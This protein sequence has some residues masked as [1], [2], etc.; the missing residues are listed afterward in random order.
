[1]L[2]NPKGKAPQSCCKCERHSATVAIAARG[3]S[4][5]WIELWSISWDDAP[6]V[7]S[8]LGLRGANNWAQIEITVLLGAVAAYECE[9]MAPWIFVMLVILYVAGLINPAKVALVAD[10]AWSANIQQFNPYSGANLLGLDTSGGDEDT[11]NEFRKKWE[12]FFS[13]WPCPRAGRDF[14]PTDSSLVNSSQAFL[15]PQL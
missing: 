7:N 12:T 11:Y 6:D 9:E 8:V 2:P 10:A 3:G 13:A 1:M 14:I 5:C 15:E 4:Y